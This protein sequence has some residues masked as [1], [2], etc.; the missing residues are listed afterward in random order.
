MA[1]SRISALSADNEVRRLAFVWVRALRDE[2]SLLNE[3]K[4]EGE[5][6]GGGGGEDCP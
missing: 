5:Q 6:L 2:I 3:A 1:L 4:R